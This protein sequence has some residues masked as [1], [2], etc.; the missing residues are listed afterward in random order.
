MS[1]IKIEF[2]P[3]AIECINKIY[4]FLEKNDKEAAKNIAK[5][6]LNKIKILEK[7]PNLGRSSIEL[8]P[9]QR[10]IIVPFGATGYVILYTLQDNVI[11]IL[12]V[13]HQKEVG[14]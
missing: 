1:S 10:E 8:E 4:T 14:Y 6:I 13:R 2:M 9:E 3:Y 7:F 5:T 11:F 12:S